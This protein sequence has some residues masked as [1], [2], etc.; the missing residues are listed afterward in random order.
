MDKM[1]VFEDGNLVR[2]ITSNKYL[3]DGQFSVCKI[4]GPI[5]RYIQS[6]LVGTNSIMVIPRSDGNLF[7]YK[8][9]RYFNDFDWSEI[10][11]YINK[12]KELNK[13]FILGTVA[14]VE[15]IEESGINYLYIPQNDT[16]FEHGVSSFFTNIDWPYKSNELIWRG[17]CSGVGDNKSLRVRFVEHLYKNNSDIGLSNWWSEGKNISTELF[18]NRINYTELMKSKIHFILDGNGISSNMMWG[19]STNSVPILISNMKCWFS[20][21]VKE[22]EHYISIKHDLSD[23]DEKLE[24]IKN[25]DDK[26]EQIAKNAFEF[27][28]EFFSPQ[29]QKT[30][31][32]TKIDT[33]VSNYRNTNKKNILTIF[34]GRK[35]NLEILTKYLKKALDANIIHEVHLW[36]NTR[37]IDDENYIK[38]ISNLKRTSSF[39]EGKYIN[40]TPVI[41]NNSFDLFIQATNDIHIKINDYEI[42]IGGWKNT[43]SVIRKNNNEI[44]S[45]NKENIISNYKQKYTFEVNNSY[46]NVYINDIK[47]ISCSIDKN[48]CIN[49][50]NILF[51]TGFGCSAIID[52]LTTLNN[53][54]Y[55][56]DTCEKSWKNY[57]QFY[58]KPEYTNDVILKC[59]DDIVFIDLNKLPNFIE[60]VRNNNNEIVFANTI[61]NGVSAYYQQNKYKLIPTEL[62]KLEYPNGGFCGTLWESGKKAELLH[63]YFI[64]NYNKFLEFNYN[65][66]VIPINTRFSINFFGIKGSNWHKIVNVYPD[67]EHHLTVSCVTQNG[68]KNVLYTDFYVSHL[69]FY[70]Q[71]ETGINIDD[72]LEKYNNLYLDFEKKQFKDL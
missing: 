40:I 51:K 46:I 13:V 35:A 1:L 42:V 20:E 29:F 23:L 9:D 24:W 7:S 10:E 30:Y 28:K 62:M 47:V 44:Y 19:F 11:F 3:W 2:N 17:S 27:T 65:L 8:D 5:V 71:I 36:N 22:N 49:N 12:A 54:F 45:L 37:N 66:E 58:N 64:N 55:L 39:N 57:Y 34:A 18:K 56:M 15:G 53:N 50:E 26:S 61:N 69:S 25:N 59:D 48:I 16:F 21:F 70:K 4:D 60:F 38:T 67:D 14:Q 41:K 68:F 6:L 72:L 33:F 31:L 52:Y 63:N 32:K 43:K